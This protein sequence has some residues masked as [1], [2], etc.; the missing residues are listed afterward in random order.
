VNSACPEPAD[1]GTQP[2]TCGETKPGAIE[3][4][5]ETDTYT[6]LGTAGDVMLIGINNRLSEQVC[7]ALYGPDGVGVGG[8]TCDGFSSRT[9]SSPMQ[10]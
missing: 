7:W 9:L 8:A 5:G 4:A 6:F 1:D 3:V 2:I 10:L